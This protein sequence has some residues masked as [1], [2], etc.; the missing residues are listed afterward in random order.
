FTQL[1]KGLA[2]VLV[3]GHIVVQLLPLAVTYLALIPARTIPFAWNLLTAGYIE[4]TTY[5]AAISIFALLFI[6]KLL[7]P[8]WG[9]KE[10]VKFILVV[11]F[12]TYV[13]V[14]I[15]AIAFYYA[16]RLEI[17]L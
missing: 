14:F 9:S 12:L 16:T 5:G 4:Q 8:I 1:C 11:N 17:Y 7:E 13:C 2:V 3:G 15:T 10:F 6:G